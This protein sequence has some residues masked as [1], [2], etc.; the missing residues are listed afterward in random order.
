MK[1]LKQSLNALSWKN[2]NLTMKVEQANLDKNPHDKDLKEKEVK[3]LNEYNEAAN[4]EE[5]LLFQRAK[6]EWI[7]KGDRNNQFF[8]KIIKIRR[9]VNKITNICDDDGHVKDALMNFEGVF[10]TKLSNDEA[11]EM[12]KEIT[13][14]EI[15]NAIFDIGESK[16]PGTDGYTSTFFKKAWKIVGNDV[17]MAIKEFFKT[18]KLLGEMNATIISLIPKVSAPNKVSDYRPIACCNVIY[19]CISKIIT[20]RIKPGLHKLVN[21]NQSAFIQG[22]VIQDNIL[23]TQE[24]LKGYDRKSEPSRCCI[25]ID[26][27]KAY[28]T[29]DWRFLEM[30]LSQFRKGYFPSG[31]GLRQGDPMSPCLF[32]LVIEDFTLLM[33]KNVQKNPKFKF[34]VGCKELKITH[35]YFADD[36]LVVCNGDVESIKV[37][38][39]TM[40]EFSG[41]SGLIPNMEKSIIF[42]GNVTNETIL[43]ILDILPFTVGKLSIKYLGIPLITKKLTSKECKKLI[44]KVKF[45]VEDWKNKYLSYAG[46]LQLIASVLSSLNVCWAAVFKIPKAVVNDIDKILKGFIWCNGEIK[47]GKAKNIAANKNTLWVK[48]V[49][50]VKLKGRSI[51]EI[52]KEN[53]DSWIWKTLLDLRGRI[54]RH[55][56][57]VLGNGKK[58]N[59][60]EDETKWIDRHGNLID[61]S[62]KIAWD[63]ISTQY[64]EVDCVKLQLI[65][66]KVKKSSNADKVAAK[67]NVMMNY[68]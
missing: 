36:L 11:M 42:F 60:W 51:W 56:M 61:F 30:A 59:V 50:V 16:A 3:A 29:V 7:S 63:T 25:K 2:G 41:I 49:N 15:K 66:L 10:G 65:G 58:S 12:I 31:R 40:L 13:D 21:L 62:S 53:N 6:V 44:D 33:A 64:A 67:C 24:L 38:K 34:H 20:E 54:K 19:K 45:R 9:Q 37:I 27:A 52:K 5:S 55:V 32:T 57:K 48:W 39:S 14:S 68:K 26:I 43:K 8:Y 23:I 18:R 4:Y 1:A 35:L 46:R 47:R 28:D 17:C 22:R